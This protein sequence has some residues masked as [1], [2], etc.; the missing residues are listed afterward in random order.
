MYKK[1][2]WF[3]GAG[4]LIARPKGG[5]PVRVA[6]L[7]GVDI[8]I[9]ATPKNLIGSRQYAEASVRA[10]STIS[11]KIQSGRF[12]GRLI[13]NLF[14]GASEVDGSIQSGLIVP[15]TDEIVT[16]DDDGS[17]TPKLGGAKFDSDLGAIDLVSRGAYKWVKQ[18]PAAGEYTY[19]EATGDYTFSVDDAGKK[20]ALSYLKF[21]S[22]QGTTTTITNDEMGEQQSF[23]LISYDKKGLF[24]QLYA[25]QFNKATLQRKNDDYLIP[26]L[27]FDAYADDIRGVGRISG[28]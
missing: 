28:A 1:A 19:D 5:T 11:G 16:I 22:T 10:G 24:I 7:Q 13:S 9:G 18:D 25:C 20:V 14:L 3:F 21:D 4:E 26:N 15:V 23:E 8:D 2:N 17:A 27:E 12:D 6:T